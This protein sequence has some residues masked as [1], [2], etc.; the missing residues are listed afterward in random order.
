MTRKNILAPL[1]FIFLQLK[2]EYSYSAFSINNITD[3][4]TV[5]NKIA[6]A[7]N[8]L[9]NNKYSKS[10]DLLFSLLPNNNLESSIKINFLI[11]NIYDQT[12]TYAKSITHYR[13]SLNL[14]N[15]YKNIDNA[16][17]SEELVESRLKTLLYLSAAYIREKKIDSA[18]HFL[19]KLIKYKSINKKT[20]HYLAD[21]HS[22]LSGIYLKYKKDYSL[23]EKY[24]LKSIGI[25]TKAEG[26]TKNLKL[27]NN[28]GNLASIYAEKK[29]FFKAKKYYLKAL[30]LT[31]SHNTPEALERKEI[32]YDNLAWTL[33]N[34]K[35]YKAFEY[36]DKSVEIREKSKEDA[37]KKELKK[38]ELLHN[39]DLIKKDE[40]SKRLE[41][42]RKNWIIAIIGFVISL[43]F[44]FLANMYKL[45]QRN[46]GLKLSKKELEQQK[47]LNELKSESQIKIINATIDGK[48]SERKQIAE[49]L[50][51]NVSALLSSANLH[52]QATKKQFKGELPIELQ[53]TQQ[54]ILEASQQI[55][56][57]SHNLVSSVLL[58][59]G[60]A[61][62]VKDIAQKY[63][64]S[65]IKI[66]LANG[67]I[68]RYTQDIEIKIFNIIQEL[69]N[70]VLKHSKAKNTY[71]VL[72][73]VNNILSIVVK[74]DGVGFNNDK[75]KSGIGLNQIQARI[76]VMEGQFNLESTK[77]KGTKISI[78]LPIIK[79]SDSSSNFA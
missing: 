75:T 73:E 53:K 4:L 68:N 41:L 33:Y 56:D 52:L 77:Q 76:E 3:S 64:N 2:V 43:V 14:N 45:Q 19:E 39:I 23:A 20:S 60:L 36:L 7:K 57:L 34:L 54:I 8:L 18:T 28:Y 58:K 24:I 11:G 6:I 42:R 59:F 40:E 5:E 55:R 62:A 1:I 49:T 35:D 12:S 37:L 63:S 30:N 16:P 66:H 51:D 47:E 10:L 74:D 17:E 13:R 46:L 69:I 78:I 15:T 48:E 9:E 22:N 50:H 38:I 27:S 29:D 21:A 31:K 32:L 65:D 61:Y 71:I 67:H 72:E 26:F 70:N 25:Y 79:R 44:F